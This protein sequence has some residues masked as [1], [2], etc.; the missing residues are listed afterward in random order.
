MFENYKDILTPLEIKDILGI[1]WN[2]VYKLL[3][4]GEIKNFKIGRE[5]KI[6]KVY[7]IQYIEREINYTSTNT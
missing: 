4:T 6:P 3:A 7:L 5:R 2:A 1:G